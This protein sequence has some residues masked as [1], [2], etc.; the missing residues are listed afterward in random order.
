MSYQMAEMKDMRA[1][2]EV[3]ME[4]QMQ[5]VCSQIQAMGTMLKNVQPQPAP[6]SS[7]IKELLQDTNISLSKPMK[8]VS[9]KP[10]GNVITLANPSGSKQHLAIYTPLSQSLT[11]NREAISTSTR[12]IWPV[13]TKLIPTITA[14]HEEEPT[15]EAI[16]INTS[17][18]GNTSLREPT[19][20]NELTEATST[21]QTAIFQTQPAAPDAKK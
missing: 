10:T 16:T 11:S 1:Q 13:S 9:L 5:E 8:S 15:C 20:T 14:S 12:V 7:T 2:R 18:M 17:S 3:R 6:A 21:F 4:A 19:R